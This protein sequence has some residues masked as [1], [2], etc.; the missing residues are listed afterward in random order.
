MP[1]DDAGRRAIG[2]RRLGP[3][4]VTVATFCRGGRGH[5]GDEVR[6]QATGEVVQTG[7][8]DTDN[9]LAV[10]L[11][12]VAG[13]IDIERALCSSGALLPSPKLSTLFFLHLFSTSLRVPLVSSSLDAKARP[14]CRRRST[15][16]VVAPQRR[17]LER[18]LR[19]S[20]ESNVTRELVGLRPCPNQPR[21]F[22][23]AI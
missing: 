20:G 5:G 4:V 23:Q 19:Y 3:S 11:N 6:V 10:D 13:P 2:S 1:H 17:R 12:L 9:E 15:A 22:A 18:S 8:R 7:K 14:A 21:E 16:V